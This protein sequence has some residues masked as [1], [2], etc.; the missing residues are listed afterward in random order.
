MIAEQSRSRGRLSERLSGLQQ[1]QG[2]RISS[3]D[4]FVSVFFGSVLIGFA[5]EK[6]IQGLNWGLVSIFEVS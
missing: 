1:G 3:G 2:R 5:T 4:F 6:M